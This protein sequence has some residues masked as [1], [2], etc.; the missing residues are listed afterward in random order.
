MMKKWRKVL[1]ESIK[2]GIR[3]ELAAANPSRAQD[4]NQRIVQE[5][6][7]KAR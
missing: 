4:K 5:W 6:E 3:A 2:A 7:A 1:R